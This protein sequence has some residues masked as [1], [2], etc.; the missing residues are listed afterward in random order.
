MGIYKVGSSGSKNR[1]TDYWHLN[2]NLFDAI[3]G[4]F[5]DFVSFEYGGYY[6]AAFARS[7]DDIHLLFRI[8][9]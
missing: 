3:E 9:C 6:F 1:R 7:K 8:R 2:V 4:K 5:R